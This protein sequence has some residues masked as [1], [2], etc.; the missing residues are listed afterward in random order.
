[1]KKPLRHLLSFI[2]IAVLACGLSLPA[3]A[4][5]TPEIS[6]QLGDALISFEDVKPIIQEGRTILPV[7]AIAE[8]L[9]AQVSY[10][11]ETQ[12]ATAVRGDT[13]VQLV[14]G[15][16]TVTIT[17][18]DI[19]R[20]LQMDVA[21]Y[22]LNNR[23][24]VPARFV[25]QAFDCYVG[26]DTVERTVL[27]LDAESLLSG[28]SAEYTLMNKLLASSNEFSQNFAVTGTFNVS[29]E[30]NSD[31]TVIPIVS[32]GT[33]SGISDTSAVNL[34]MEMST[35]ITGLITALGATDESPE[36]ALILSMLQDIQLEYIL[37]IGD[38]MLYIRC[39]LLA[40]M[41]GADANAWYSI[42]TTA[43]LP[44]TD[45]SV[46]NATTAAKDS[47][48]DFKDYIKSIVELVQPSDVDTAA[49]LAQGLDIINTNFSD[50]AFVQSGN[51]YTS[52][53][54]IDE[55]GVTGSVSL[56]LTVTDDAVTAYSMRFTVVDTDVSME[57]NYG[58]DANNKM[59]FSINMSI[60][61][62]LELNCTAS[63]QYS[64]STSP[65]AT[66]PEAG[67]LIIPMPLDLPQDPLPSH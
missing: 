28:N 23:M 17:K 45:A 59:D 36:T 33:V 5:S 19:T 14:V 58:M 25:A 27:I 64:K 12:T 60:P 22:I 10:N 24:M 48:A 21:S 32:N 18:G 52:T 15:E 40:S 11:N 41:T 38:G 16:D 34:D 3:F 50:A 51:T 1:M 53:L 57:L 54:S 31:G 39:P 49:A 8:A 30:I 13:T 47:A 66:E 42:D 2:L 67:S 61:D 37:N 7:R 20:T 35:D 46:F 65:A 6:V 29:A 4:V 43:L 44:D 62:T 63:L 26:W 56:S 55:D 9:G